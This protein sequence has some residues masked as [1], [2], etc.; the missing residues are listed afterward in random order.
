[1]KF[2]LTRISEARGA[3][4]MLF[5]L[6]ATHLNVCTHR[7]SRRSSSASTGRSVWRT[8]PRCCCSYWQPAP[9]TPLCAA[10]APAWQTAAAPRGSRKRTSPPRPCRKSR[11]GCSRRRLRR[12]PDHRWPRPLR[13]FAGSRTPDKPSPACCLLHM[14][15]RWNSVL[16]DRCIPRNITVSD[17]GESP[18]LPVETREKLS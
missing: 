6:R 5:Y 10:D 13:L 2:S 16:T 4:F 8:C 14:W 9:G 18:V 15:P 12:R 3:H 17:P 1:M 7:R 11:P